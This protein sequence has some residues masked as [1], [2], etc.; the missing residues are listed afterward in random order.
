MPNNKMERF[1]QQARHVMLLAQEETQ[2]LRHHYIDSEHLLLG[3]MKAEGGIA[4]RVLRKLGLEQRRIEDLVEEMTRATAA[5]DLAAVDLSPAV[6][7][8]LESAVDEAR[9]MGHHYI[10]TEHLLL[11][12]VRQSDSVAVE[13]LK[14]LGVSPEEVRR[15]V[16]R[17]L[18]EPPPSTP[19]SEGRSAFQSPPSKTEPQPSYRPL[20][21]NSDPRAF[22]VL[23]AAITRILD[24]VESQK[25]T[26]EQGME[27]L[28]GLQPYLAPSTGQQ[29]RLVAQTLGLS[30]LDKH[31][32]RFVIRHAQT[33]SVV[34][35]INASLLE[36]TDSLDTF[37][38][39]VIAKYPGWMWVQ[40][41]EGNYLLEIKVEENQSSQQ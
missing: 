8:I 2:R 34:F 3:L 40:N 13:I 16:R 22:E 28:A 23:Q 31:Q 5:A 26:S 11:G 17:V 32:L 25:L 38:N 6:K 36:V 14:R 12:L 10:G 1:T 39:A 27:L 4:G 30:Q 24:M 19:P 33:Q 37:I 20:I 15:Q 29:T 41:I 35:E 21:R 9:R 18:Q 7:R